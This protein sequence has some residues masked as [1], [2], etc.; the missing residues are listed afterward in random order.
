MK[1]FFSILLAIVA[2]SAISAAEEA[3]RD[4]GFRHTKNLCIK[5]YDFKFIKATPDKSH[6]RMGLFK[7]R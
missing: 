4:Y 5:G 7:F 2:A 1:T 3:K 6:W